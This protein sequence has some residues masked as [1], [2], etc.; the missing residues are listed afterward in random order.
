MVPCGKGILSSGG[1]LVNPL[2]SL[3]WEHSKRIP[4]PILETTLLLSGNL[5]LRLNSELGSPGNL[6]PPGPPL[7][8]TG[9]TGKEGR[10]SWEPTRYAPN[11][12]PMASG[13]CSSQAA[14]LCPCQ[15]A[16]PAPMPWTWTALGPA[17]EA[18]VPLPCQWVLWWGSHQDPEPTGR[19]RPQ[20][21][22]K[23]S[24]LCRPRRNEQG[25]SC[26]GRSRPR[27]RLIG[28]RE[29]LG[30]GPGVPSALRDKLGM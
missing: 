22:A 7:G 24:C 17:G 28:V 4:E 30:N 26:K 19:L 9:S 10:I 13:L 25:C 15:L 5:G 23:G 6:A 18:C 21:Q 1:T 2:P 29:F 16:S 12:I 14:H 8:S 3:P 11:P 27:E 20:G